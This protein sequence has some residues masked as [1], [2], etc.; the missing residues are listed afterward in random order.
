MVENGIHIVP[1]TTEADTVHPRG[2][3]IETDSTSDILHIPTHKMLLGI[4]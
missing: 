4:M 2:G 3:E 1:C